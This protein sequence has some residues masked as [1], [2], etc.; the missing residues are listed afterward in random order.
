MEQ[1]EIYGPRG[2]ADW[3]KGPLTGETYYLGVEPHPFDALY[4]LK[5]YDNRKRVIW[6]HWAFSAYDEAMRAY[7]RVLSV[8]LATRDAS[9]DDYHHWSY[10]FEGR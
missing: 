10:A 9:M 6:C 8:L 3:T 1:L 2:N 7:D 5:G 4:A